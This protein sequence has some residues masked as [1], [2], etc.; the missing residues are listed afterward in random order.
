MSCRAICQSG[1]DRDISNFKKS[2]VRDP[3]TDARDDKKR[4]DLT[5]LKTFLP[6]RRK[7]SEGIGK[8]ERNLGY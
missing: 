3:S 5:P 1:S 2:K 6:R 7:F 8:T 4:G